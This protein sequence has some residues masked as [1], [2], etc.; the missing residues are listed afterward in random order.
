MPY[1]QITPP[2]S[3]RYYVRIWLYACS[4]QPCYIGARVVEGGTAAP[5][6]QTPESR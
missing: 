2:Q 3:G 6:L 1:V 4:N 5:R